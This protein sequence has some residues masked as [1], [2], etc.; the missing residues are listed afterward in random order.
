MIYG[1]IIY[2]NGADGGSGI[3]MDGVQN[4]RIENNLL[5]DNHAS[6]IS[7]Y[8]IDGGGGSNGNVVANNTIHVADDGRWAL[9]IKD[10]STGN[11]AFNNILVSEHNTYG[12]IDIDAAS[13]SGFVSDYNV[14]KDKFSNDD[15]FISLAAWRSQTGQ[16]LHSI[17]AQPGA[18]FENWNAGDYELL[19]TAVARDAGVASLARKVGTDDRSRRQVSPRRRS[20]RRRRVRIWCGK[21]P[22]RLQS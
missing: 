8:R 15:S 2:G 18:L 11:T 1:N 20:V 21:S 17:A 4:S 22:R 10:G 6:G 12:A 14:V 9:N 5:Y 19:A 13:R 3:N 16:D 7:L